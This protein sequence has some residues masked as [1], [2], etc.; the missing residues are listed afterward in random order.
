MTWQGN[1]PHST[2]YEQ[3]LKSKM[4]LLEK[5]Q[6]ECE[7]DS[8]AIKGDLAVV[9]MDQIRNIFVRHTKDGWNSFTDITAEYV[10]SRF[11]SDGTA[12]D[13][14]QFKFPFSIGEGDEDTEWSCSMEFAIA[15]QVHNIESWDNNNGKNYQLHLRHLDHES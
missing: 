2:E 10:S 15:Y 11:T 14:F 4:V 1:E 3:L 9:N 12:F 5:C 8:H 6:L 13:L 7:E